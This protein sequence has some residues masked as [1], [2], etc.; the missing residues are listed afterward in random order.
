MQCLLDSR[1]GEIGAKLIVGDSLTFLK[2]LDADSVDLLVTSPPYFIGK[3]YDISKSIEGFEQVIC[4]LLPE[5]ERVVKTGGSI[6]WQVGNHVH[7]NSILPLDHLAANA[8]KTTS[9]F[10]LR[11]RIIWMFSHGIHAKRRFSGRHETILWYTKGE[12]Y[13]F[14]LDS[15]R[16]PQKY[17]GKKHYKG[18][19]RGEFSGNPLGKNP[20]DF[21]EIGAVWDIP[22]VKA[23]HVEKTEHPCQFPTA[24]V[25]RLI[26]ALCPKGGLVLDP[27]AGSGTTAIAALI[28]GRN[29]TGCDISVKYLAIAKSRLDA[30]SAGTL[31]YRE[32]EPIF[33]PTGKES[34]SKV[35][36]HFK[37]RPE[38]NND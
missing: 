17:P 23:N 13:Y 22:N 37:V 9:K 33:V 3:E 25:R 20:S 10:R 7:K 34:V 38:E 2:S 19:K 21:W 35:P 31:R 4:E 29:C 18:P 36:S 6:C 32:D 12:D 16:I 24:L 5:A 14:D 15:V 26:R 1:F 11:N 8:M 30:L 27:F 28:E